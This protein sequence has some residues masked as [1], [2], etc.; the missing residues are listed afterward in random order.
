MISNVPGQIPAD[1][2]PLAETISNI[3]Y[4]PQFVQYRIP[5][6]NRDSLTR[7]LSHLL[8][9]T[10]PTFGRELQW[11]DFAQLIPNHNLGGSPPP[12]ESLYPV[13]G[14]GGG[15]SPPDISR[16][17]DII[18]PIVLQIERP[19]PIHLH[20]KVISGV[21]LARPLSELWSHVKTLWHVAKAIKILAVKFFQSGFAVGIRSFKDEIGHVRLPSWQLLGRAIKTLAL[22][23]FRWHLYDKTLFVYGWNIIHSLEGRIKISDKDA[24]KQA[25]PFM[26]ENAHYLKYEPDLDS[27][28]FEENTWTSLQEISPQ[29]ISQ[30]YKSNYQVDLTNKPSH[31]TISDLLKTDHLKKT[32][33]ALL[34]ECPIRFTT[35]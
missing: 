30:F 9:Y 5:E 33:S 28:N 1:I 34:D 17:L 11:P 26:L 7:S 29:T 8:R 32:N 19:N 24:I 3:F 16:W 2:H 27:K 20:V 12:P 18:R 31:N 15:G 14:G 13:N 21:I 4:P 6:S 22:A 23:L 35:T 10:R 25:Y